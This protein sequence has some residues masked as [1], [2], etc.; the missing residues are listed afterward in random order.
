MLFDD[1]RKVLKRIRRANT[2]WWINEKAIV[3][4]NG[5][6]YIVYCTDVGEVH[7]REKNW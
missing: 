6:T 3:A 1:N 4:D 5:K 2:D 7:I